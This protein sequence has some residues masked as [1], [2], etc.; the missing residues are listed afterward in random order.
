[1]AGLLAGH[2]GPSGLQGVAPGS[3]ILP[4][5][6]M[7]WR[8][9]V[10]GSWAVLGRGDSCSPG[11]SGLSIPTATATSRTAPRSRSS[12]AYSPTRRLR[13]APRRGPPPAPRT[14][15]RSWS[16]LSGTTAARASGSGRRGARGRLGGARGGDARRPPGGAGGRR[17]AAR[18]LRHG[19]RRACSPPRRYSTGNR[20]ALRGGD[21][22]RADAVPGRPRGRHPGEAAT[23]GRLLRHERGQPR[24]RQGRRRAGETRER[25]RR[26]A[27]HAAEAG[28]G[29]VL[30]AGT[31][32]PAGS[33]DLEGIVGVPIVAIPAEAGQAL[34]QAA[35][36]STSRACAL[37]RTRR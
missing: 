26:R 11:W 7:G 1:M 19:A 33:L 9:T 17:R 30:V 27:R 12:G 36:R 18:R 14:S 32:L 8:Q 3:R 4:I 37:S 22:C 24:S 10:E 23:P 20:R 35:R 29:A 2:D 34:S 16:L 13:T 28:A 25:S 15:G 5:R 6:V 21:G 31:E